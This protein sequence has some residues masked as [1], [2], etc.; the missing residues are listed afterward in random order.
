MMNSI[1]KV[2]VPQWDREPLEQLNWNVENHPFPIP[3]LVWL[4]F[5]LILETI[6]CL[7]NPLIRDVRRI[8]D[9]IGAVPI[10]DRLTQVSDALKAASSKT[11][12]RFCSFMR[13][14]CIIPSWR[15]NAY[16]IPTAVMV[17]IP[18][19]RES[20]PRVRQTDRCP[21]SNHDEPCLSLAHMHSWSPSS[22]LMEAF[23]WGLEEH[24]FLPWKNAFSKTYPTLICHDGLY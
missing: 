7:N 15:D 5:F 6:H 23:Q 11:R 9:E 10:Q 19:L 18:R 17:E 14:A 22:Q 16:V 20:Q 8:P 24:L 1:Y 2:S 21:I 3:V 13:C 12:D 4:S